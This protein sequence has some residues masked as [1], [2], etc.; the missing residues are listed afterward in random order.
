MRRGDEAHRIGW[1]AAVNSERLLIELDPGTT[2]LVKGGPAGVLPVGSINSYVTVPAGPARLVGVVTAIE[3]AEE[4]PRG[5]DPY[6]AE[7]ALSRR[8]DAV[9]VGRL[10]RGRYEMGVATYPPLYSPVTSAT[11]SDLELIFK[12]GEGP[13]IPIG[14]AV[15]APELN[16]RLDA[17]RLMARH[18]AVLG[19]TGSGK[20][21]TV[22]AVVEELLRLDVPN[23]N[24]IVFDANGEYSAAF[25]PEADR[26]QLADI[27]VLGPQTGPSGALQVPH[28]FMDNEDH[29]ALFRASEGTQAPLLQRGVADARLAGS[30]ARGDL[31]LLRHVQ[32]VT[33]EAL[34]VLSTTERKPQAKL[35][36]LLGDLE[37]FLRRLATE[38]EGATEVEWGRL[39]EAAREVEDLNLDAESWDPLSVKQREQLDR[40]GSKLR[41]EVEGAL[42]ELGLGSQ[43]VAADFDAPRYYSLEELY[44]TF[45]PQRIALES[46][47]E[48]RMQAWAAPLMMRLSRM[49][50]DGRYDFMTKVDPHSESLAR[51]LRLLFGYD[52]LQNC[53]EGE[54]PPWAEEYRNRLTGE[55]S[56]N[57]V[58]T[59]LD[60]SLVAPDVLTNV[61]ALIGRLILDFLQRIDPRGSLPALLILEEAHRYLPEDQ[62]TRARVTFERIAKE[63]RKFGLGMLLAS[64]R[65]SELARTVLSQCGTLIA[66][67]TVNP[68][69][70]ELIRYATPFASREVLRQLPG[71]ATQHAV[72][73]G[74]AAPVPSYVRIRDVKDPPEG[75]DPDFVSMWQSPLPDSG[76]F[77]RVAWAWEQ[78]MTVDEV[79]GRSEA[80]EGDEPDEA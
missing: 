79:S 38:L 23:A 42:A 21:C 12:P 63:G 74:E 18:A 69:D 75:R 10:Q 29:L 50:A 8:M 61:A 32:R 35:V 36:A 62:E 44:E 43:S 71:L 41:A 60:L 4:A 46:V 73:L 48:P 58:V 55:Q 1:V 39:A 76:V 64:Q 77:E 59:I 11:P 7:A 51:F 25:G 22:T 3:L 30:A 13:T 78:G 54:E 20:S 16:F 17:N 28:W 27:C 52:P 49:L 45:L 57:H 6:A 33:G 53:D 9:I 80:L 68:T 66:H 47:A 14:E 2:G 72:V 70:Q 24:I 56:R 31:S 26:G 34:D 40:I 65:P 5:K 15:V 67:R 37:S 19:S